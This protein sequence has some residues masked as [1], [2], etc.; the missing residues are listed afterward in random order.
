MHII[1]NHEILPPQEY[2][3]FES[4]AALD[5]FN[6]KEARG[7]IRA[8]GKREVKNGHKEHENNFGRDV[9]TPRKVAMEAGSKIASQGVRIV[10]HWKYL[11]SF[12]TIYIVLVLTYLQR[13]FGV[14]LYAGKLLKSE[15]TF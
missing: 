14:K 13:S 7:A 9:S 1:V 2:Q 6:L 10:K 5:Q 4:L 11:I 15:R 3:N 8:G 12:T